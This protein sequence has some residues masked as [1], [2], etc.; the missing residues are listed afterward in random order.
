[1]DQQ[2]NLPK[3]ATDAHDFVAGLA[4]RMGSLGVEVA[5]IAGHVDTVNRALSDQ[6]Q[7]V[8][9]LK[10]AIGDLNAANDRIAAAGTETHAQTRGATETIAQSRQAAGSAADGVDGLIASILQMSERLNRLDDALNRVG[11][12]AGGIETIARQTNLLALNATIEAARA[13]EAGRGF[14]VVAGEVK[15]LANETRTATQQIGDTA[16]LL[17]SE[18]DSLRHDLTAT[19]TTADRVR[20]GTKTIARS[21]DA[22]RDVFAVVDRA[23]QSVADQVAANARIYGEVEGRLGHLVDGVKK[24]ATDLGVADKRVGGLLSLSEELIEHIAACGIETDDTRFIAAVTAA[25]REIAQIFELSVA[26]GTIAEADLFDE[27][28]KPVPGSN[29]PQ[30]TTRFVQFT[31]RVL[32]PIQER[33]LGFDPRVAFCAAVD[34]NGYLPTHN[35]KFSQAQGPDPVWNAANCR[36]RRI[37]NDRTGLAAGRNTKP[38]LLQTYR[39]D[40]GGSYVMM[41]DLSVPIRVGGRHWG[42]LRLGYKPA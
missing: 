29:P 41:K 20:D 32:P 12:V 1:M 16:K 26:R 19:S 21:I 33:M 27:T 6:A 17:T 35:T 24:S 30:V 5:D 37:F 13:G 42:G 18:I 31:D 9:Q 36:N 4:T 14:A 40:M 23:A 22:V 2:H 25:A 8:E 28:Y 38:F 15:S 34:R 39:R 3:L 10:A 11:K 7:Q